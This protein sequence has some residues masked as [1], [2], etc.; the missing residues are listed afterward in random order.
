M[1]HLATL[2][3]LAATLFTIAISAQNEPG[4]SNQL[5]QRFTPPPNSVLG[6]ETGGSKSNFIGSGE[7]TNVIKFNP[8]LLSRNIAAVFYERYITEEFSLTGGL[9]F[10]YGKDFFT[11]IGSSMDF[12]LIESNSISLF[13]LS[14]MMNRGTF[15][16]GGNYF[17]SIALRLYWETYDNY[18]TAYL[19]LNARNYKNTLSLTESNYIPLHDITSVE[20]RNTTYNFI[21]GTQIST[22]GNIKTVHDIY[23]GFGVRG[24][25]YNI[26]ETKS[27]YDSNGIPEERL[28]KTQNHEKRYFPMFLVGYI[29]GFG[30]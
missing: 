2:L 30:F 12:E 13:S 17:S 9:G 7:L 11:Q 24:T 19:E 26:F 18:R 14:D 5:D 22:H 8:I 1:K 28:L 27:F 6:K 23:G 3:T 10:C 20:I 16:S 15:V 4:I 25:R 21:I 29:F